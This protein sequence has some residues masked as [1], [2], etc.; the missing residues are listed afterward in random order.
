LGGIIDVDGDV[1][2]AFKILE[3]PRVPPEVWQTIANSTQ[4]AESI[5]GNDQAFVQGTVPG[6]KSSVVRTATGAGNVA[7]ASATRIAGP[8]G[9]FC[10]GVLIPFVYALDDM[11]RERMPLTEV[12][13]ILSAELGDDFDLDYDDFLNAEMKFEVLA[14]AHLAA[15]KAMAQSLPL[16]L[17]IFENPHLLEQMNAT[18]WTVDV[19]ELFE[20][21]LEMSEWKNN[22]DI[23]RK[24]TQQE[25]QMYQAQQQ[26]PMQAAMA[27]TQMQAQAQSALVDKKSE[28]KL[29][30][31]LIMSHAQS[32]QSEHDRMLDAGERA[33]DFAMRTSYE[34]A[35]AASPYLGQ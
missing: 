31:D 10:K 34:H 4:T 33:A 25:L 22:R 18:G 14:G 21:L 2:K 29:S 24:M 5:D 19:R 15:K 35:A 11:V 9:R 12:R 20:M 13:S 17:Q 32:R 16:M 1:E 7:A 30:H 27:K 26:A 28:A 23:I 8:V 3:P 6:P